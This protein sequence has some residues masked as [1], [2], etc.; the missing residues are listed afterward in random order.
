M[1]QAAAELI[2]QTTDKLVPMVTDFHGAFFDDQGREIPITEEM[3]RKACDDLMKMWH[4][5][6]K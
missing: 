4:F 2:K 5:P 1:L 3:I 6:S